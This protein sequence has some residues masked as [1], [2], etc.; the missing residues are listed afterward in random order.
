M[1][2][3]TAAALALALLLPACGGGGSSNDLARDLRAI[4]GLQFPDLPMSSDRAPDRPLPADAPAPSDALREQGLEGG[5]DLALDA[6]KDL[7]PADTQPGPDLPKPDLWKGGPCF[8]EWANW[9]CQSTGTGCNAG[10]GIAT[11]TCVNITWVTICTCTV[12]GVSKQCS[13]VSGSGC[14]RCSNAFKSGC[15]VAP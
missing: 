5:A 12:N 10:C 15:C 11:L 6:A 4:E 7:V 13:G 9:T 2:R 14:T 1:R 3:S 8:Y